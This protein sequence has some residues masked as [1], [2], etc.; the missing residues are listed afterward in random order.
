VQWHNNADVVTQNLQIVPA[1][2]SFAN[3]QE[4]TVTGASFSQVKPVGVFAARNIFRTKV[5]GLSPNT[6]YKYRM[7]AA[8]AWSDTYY[9]TTSSGT[10]AAFSF[11]VVSDPQSDA[12]SDMQ[13]TLRAADAFDTDSRFYLMGGDVVNEI[14]KVPAEIVSYTEAATEFNKYRPI[15]ATQGNH[16]TYY[17]NGTDNQYRFGESTVFNAFVAFPDNGWDTH[18]DKANRSQSYY[19]Y[20]NKVL[21]IVLNTMATSA[22]SGTAEPNHT[23]QANWLKEILE[24]DRTEKLSNYRIVITHVSPLSGRDTERWLTPGVRSAYGKICTDNA[25]DIF[26][27]GHDHVYAR[28]NPIKIGTNT[29][30]NSMN[31]NETEGGTI[32]S[33]VSAT[34]PKFYTIDNANGVGQYFPVK[35]DAST[36]GVFVNVKVTAEKLIVTAKRLGVDTP[37]DTYQVTPKP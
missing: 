25:V 9:H 27:A 3:A 21:V 16:D 37:L 31:F 22:N 13:A 34:G 24:K 23:A 15:A 32:F 12:H 17:D 2:G 33:I 26:F 7:G 20:Y 36:P 4:I 8:G 5:T 6:L 14:G 11:T 35:T 18:A 28:S 29:A 30:L 10:A 19:F 1:G